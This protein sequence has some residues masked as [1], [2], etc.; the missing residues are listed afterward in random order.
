MAW[1]SV[2]LEHEVR[3]WLE[4]LSLRHFGAAAFH[5]DLLADQG[6]LLGEP[7][8]RQLSGKL[9]ELR[10][11]VGGEATR[12]SYWVAPGR[13][14][15]LLTVFQKRRMRETAEIRR[16]MRAMERCQSEMHLVEDDDD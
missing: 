13:R 2:E 4:D 16:A 5:I 10:F 11:H 3:R 12:V 6:P 7:Y 1:G 8:T 15:I 9:R 14:I